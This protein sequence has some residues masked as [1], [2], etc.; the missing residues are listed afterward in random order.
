M[1]VVYRAARSAQGLIEACLRPDSYCVI[2]SVFD[3]NGTELKSRLAIQISQQKG[4][5]NSE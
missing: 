5:P 3:G 1:N 2:R 4:C